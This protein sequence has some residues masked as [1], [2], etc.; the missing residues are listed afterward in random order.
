MASAMP[1][2]WRDLLPSLTPQERAMMD[3]ILAAPKRWSPL[4]GP[5]TRA[6]ESKAD[7][8]LYGGA[9][10]G[11]KTDLALGKALTKHRRTLILRREYPQLKGIIERARD[12]YTPFGTWNGKDS[13]WRC[14]FGGLSRIVELG[15]CQHETDKTNYQGRPHDLLVFDE[16]A[17][18]LESQV[19][20]ISGWVRTEV[21]GQAC[22]TLL[23]S[24][25]PTGAEGLWLIEWFAPWLDPKHP[26]PAAIGELRYYAMIDGR[27][28][29]VDGPAPVRHRGEL[30]TPK[31][32]T[33]IPARV[34]DNPYYMRTGY[35]AQLQA[36]PEPLRSM[37]LFGDFAASRE[38]DRYQV[39]PSEWVRAAQERWRSREKPRTQMTALG[40]DVARGGKD[41]TVISPRHDNWFAQQIAVPGKSTPDGPAVATLVLQHRRDNALVNADVIGVGYSVQDALEP[42][43]KDAF[44]PLNGSEAS[45]RRDKSGRLAFVNQRAEWWWSMREALDPATGDDLALPPDQGLLADLCAPTWK[46]TARGIQVEA[47]EDIIKRIGRSPDK[48]DSAVY[49]LAHAWLHEPLRPP[50]PAFGTPEYAALEADR[51]EREEEERIAAEIREQQGDPVGIGSSEDWESGW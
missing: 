32:R 49:A 4:P 17:N 1:S 26:K 39:V 46:L 18:F 37:M 41:Q 45:I 38:D 9:A 12:I 21:E 16:A 40:V 42:V 47:K 6:L 44:V 50:R 14:R 19:R 51:M 29:E 33:Y 36:L 43:L 20:F 23:C 30:I 25:P 5:Q 28:T 10:G 13:V 34:A 2:D 15:S 48:G 27:D 35:V 22:Q 31:S 8:L 3:A 7:V 11:G 24:N